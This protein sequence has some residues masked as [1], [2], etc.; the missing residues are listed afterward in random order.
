MSSDNYLELRLS[1][2]GHEK[3][4]KQ[5]LLD[6]NLLQSHQSQRKYSFMEYNNGV[7]FR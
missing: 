5:I 1:P 6:R 3:N 2:N 7:S 4:E